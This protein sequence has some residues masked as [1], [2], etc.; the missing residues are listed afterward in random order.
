MDNQLTF[1]GY[2]VEFTK[3]DGE[4]YIT[5]KG[6]T[7][8]LTQIEKF[9][10]KKS[11]TRY[12]FGNSNIRSYPKKIIRIDCLFDTKQQIEFLYKQAQQLK[13]E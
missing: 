4:I 1:G 6:V 12:K 10:K 5:C 13:N 8:T 11:K 7:G 3:Q 9:L 2:P